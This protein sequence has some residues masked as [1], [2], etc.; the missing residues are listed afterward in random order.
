MLE[1]AYIMIERYTHPEMGNIW[2]LENEFRTMLKVEV[3]AC[4]A[5]NK[6][7]IVP[8][9]LAE[10]IVPDWK[11]W[12]SAFSRA[13]LSPLSYQCAIPSIEDGDVFALSS[14]LV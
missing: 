10:A 3:L 4:E 11:N 6:L 9:D 14:K 2:S 5:M 13:E 12:L 8:D 1:G 7:G